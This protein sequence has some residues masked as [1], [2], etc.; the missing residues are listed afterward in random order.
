MQYHSM[1]ISECSWN[2]SAKPFS[3]DSMRY[4]G[5]SFSCVMKQKECF[6][7]LS[8]ILQDG[9][10][11][12]LERHF[13]TELF[14]EI[15]GLL[16]G[17]YHLCFQSCSHRKSCETE[18]GFQNMAQR[19]KYSQLLLT[20]LTCGPIFITST[21]A[22]YRFAG[23]WRAWLR[24]K[25][26]FAMISQDLDFLLL[27]QAAEKLNCCLFVHPWDMQIDGRMSKYWFPWLIGKC[28]FTL[29]ILQLWTGLCP[30]DCSQVQVQRKLH[31]FSVKLPFFKI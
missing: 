15:L 27:L 22:Q 24:S 19:S 20:V 6:L 4:Y 11:T 1:N 8:F 23:R 2:N 13:C 18:W 28:I 5:N 10:K 17:C 12:S 7:E 14:W 21:T 16:K 3:N 25:M 30:G 31:C 29:L 26:N 9:W